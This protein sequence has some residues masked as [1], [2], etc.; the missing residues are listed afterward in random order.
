MVK[1]E[2]LAPVGDFRSLSA[3]LKAGCDAI[4]FGLKQF[5]MRDSARNFSISELSKIR[6]IC[7]KS[8]IKMYLTLNTIVYDSEIE[9]VDKILRK[10][11]NKI[12]A[13]I[14]WDLAIIELCRKYKIPFHISTQASIANSE[15]AKFYKKLGAERVI[16]ARE[17][18]LKQ[19]REIARIIDVEIF[20]HGAMCVSV[21]GR[22]FTS[23]FLHCKSANRGM[24]RHPCRK[25]YTVKDDEGNE[26]RVENSRIFSAK[27]LCTLPFI[28]KL[29]KSGVVAFKIEGRN[30]EPEYVHEVTRIYREA[31][32]RKL[33][34]KE[35]ETYLE[36]LKKV[37]NREFSSGFY[38]KLPTADDFTKFENGSQTRTKDFVG[39][40]RH[41]YNKL[42]VAVLKIN[43][44]RLKIGDNAL[45]IGKTTFFKTKIESMEINHK[46]VT[47]AIK[48]QDVAVKL[49]RCRQNDQLYL[50]KLRTQI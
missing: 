48:G 36:E 7:S 19:I 20:V 45:V 15:S 6:K 35:I 40:I 22:C 26:L 25:A 39:K 41:Y 13:V 33:S 3:A 31:L 14:C 44:G 5:N 21:S 30:R 29:K 12:D 28:D 11:K 18:N 50:E 32:N 16:L 27:D 46:Q 47:Q 43:A 8:K 42:G 49:P 2:L 4:Y 17:L 10:I 1:Y 9:R 38:L 24:C 34:K 23:Q 37:Y